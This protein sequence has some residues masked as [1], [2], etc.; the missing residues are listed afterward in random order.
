MREYLINF[1]DEF[2]YAEDDAAKLLAAYDTINAN[3]DAAKLFANAI[4]EYDK[5]EGWD[6]QNAIIG[7]A[8]RA[9]EFCGV[10]TYTAELLVFI[11]LSKRLKARYIEKG[12]DLQIY[13]DSMLDLKWKLWE[14][15][16]VKGICGSFVSPWFV[17]FFDLTR[18][19]LGRLQFEVVTLWF[20]YEG[21]GIKFEKDKS[22]VINVHIPRTCTPIDKASCDES[23]AQA[24]RFFNERCG[25]EDYPFVCYSWM[26]YPANKDILAPESNT[27]RFLDEYVI[28]QSNDN[29]GED[30]WRLFDTDEKDPDKL[31]TDT[32]MR[33]R[34][35]QHLK[36]GGKVGEGLG[37]RKA[38]LG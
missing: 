38:E 14:C 32:S 33:R 3:D 21:N 16:A 17:G 1:F 2:K 6:F 30:L 22:H 29:N 28:I 8:K 26:L 9:A 13:H 34:Y 19:A 27:Y 4:S 35:A 12:I 18:F 10:H 37:V 11:C 15:K 7:G 5:E 36:N 31:P 20:D 25:G 24:R 23:Y